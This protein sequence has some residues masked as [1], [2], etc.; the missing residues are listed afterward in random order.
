MI[1]TNADCLSTKWE[2]FSELTR[3]RVPHV[4]VVTEVLPKHCNDPLAYF[5]HLTDYSL[6][7]NKQAKRGICIYIHTSVKF[8]EIV[9]PIFD[10]VSEC[11][12]VDIKLPSL[13][14]YLRLAAFYRSPTLGP[15]SCVN[16]ANILN[17]LTYLVKNS[18]KLLVVGDFNLPNID[19]QT[20]STSQPGE[21]YE[22]TFLDRLDDLFLHQHV[23]SPTRARGDSIPSIL[24]LVITKHVDDILG[25]EMFSP[26]GK[27]D[28]SVIQITMNTF[29]QR[30]NTDSRRYDY[31]RA[32]YQSMREF[33]VSLNITD[34]LQKGKV[35]PDVA[36]EFF[37]QALIECRDRFVPLIKKYSGQRKRPK[38][39]RHILKSIQEKNHLWRSYTKLKIEQKISQKPSSMN[40]DDDTWSLYKRARN[41]ATK[42]LRANREVVESHIIQSSKTCPKQFWKYVNRNKPNFSPSNCTFTHPVTQQKIDDDFDKACIFNETFASVF[43]TPNQTH[44]DQDLVQGIQS[45]TL[46]CN[47]IDFSVAEVHQ[48]LK[49]LDTSKSP[50]IDGFPNTMIIQIADVIAQPLTFLYNQSLATGSCPSGWKKAMVKPLHKAGLK[51]DFK[52]YRPI[53]ITSIFCRVME[54]LIVA[55]IQTYFDENNLWNPAQHG[56]RKRRSCNTQLLEVIV[57]FQHYADLGIPFDCIYIDF[58]KAFDKVSM[59]QLVEKCRLYNIGVR[60]V[61]WIADYL[62]GRSQQVVVGEAASQSIDVLSGVPQGSC[63]GPILFC[64]FIN[65]LPS[66]VRHSSVKLFADDAKIYRPILTTDDEPMLQEDLDSITRW[67]ESNSMFVNASKCAVLHYGNKNQPSR[68]YSLSGSQ[69][70]SEEFVRD[71]GVHFDTHLKFDRHVSTVVR[72]ANYQLLTLKRNFRKFNLKN[73]MLLYKSFVRPVV[74]YNTSV[75]FP[76]NVTDEHRVE[77]IQRRAT[78]MIP[79]L[80]HLP[81]AQRLTRL[82]LPSLHF[83]R[84]RTDLINTFKIIKGVDDIEVGKFFE[85]SHYHLTR[86]HP[87]KIYPPRTHRKIGHNSF[88]NRVTDSWN[89]LPPEV[90]EAG[91]VESFKN[92]LVDSQFYTSAFSV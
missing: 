33:L 45:G 77:K 28:H 82:Q 67:C 85:F 36:F 9:N 17:C 43:V 72:N 75:W 63:L 52:N 91:S 11:L 62:R 26:L 44:H 31:A 18:H 53:S 8:S 65:D 49:K 74:E 4:V 73:F 78:K 83:R 37:K 68:A 41:R 88:V 12:V 42:L 40:Q 29:V 64:I 14:N 10:L 89:N 48:I 60:T 13:N 16:D 24:D 59:S 90:V 86:Q 3:V 80:K 56:F 92:M 7:F 66:C 58:A 84:R 76:L 54:K 19:W 27:S 2:E 69:I 55:R 79:Y 25:L 22:Q 6:V 61:D 15:S 81:Y 32:D 20:L 1:Y 39:P 5:Q 71:L 70:P 30:E 34:E 23:N 35:V 21:S 50:D 87:Y 46:S 51:S 47:D 38:L 57:D